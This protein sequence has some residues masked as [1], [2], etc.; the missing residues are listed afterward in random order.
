MPTWLIGLL[1]FIAPARLN[2]DT[3]SPDL[4]VSLLVLVFIGTFAVPSLLIYYLYRSGV[5]TDLTMPDR[6]DRR[7]PYLLSG[8]VYLVVTYLFAFRMSLFSETSPEVAI[9][10]GSITLSILLVGLINTVWKISAHAVGIGGVLGTVMLM[11]A[12]HGDTELFVPF[13]ILI[14]LSGLLATARLQL[15]AHTLGQV[16]AGLGLGVLVSGLA[17]FWLV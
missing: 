1:L 17:V 3:Y 5:L 11:L 9:I 8:I 4:R 14:A 15:N 12:K 13:V 7:L 16:S 2:V 10:L 6:T